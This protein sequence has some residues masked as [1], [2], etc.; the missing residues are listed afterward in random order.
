MNDADSS[1][2]RT[3]RAAWRTTIVL[4]VA[5][6]LPAMWGFGT[7]FIELIAVFREEPDGLF[8]VIPILN[9]LLASVGFLLLLAWATSQGMFRDIEGPK[10]DMLDQERQLDS[11]A[12]ESRHD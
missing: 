3:T 8:A 10:Y 7:K 12:K 4:A 6:L 11:T 1:G 9:Y 5:I 2:S